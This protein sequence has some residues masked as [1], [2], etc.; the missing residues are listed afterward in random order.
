MFNV[1][2]RANV[3]FQLGKE[4]GAE[5]KN[6]QAFIARDGQ[7]GA[8][9]V[10]KRIEKS[11]LA[12]AADFYRESRALY[13]SAHPNVVQVHYAC[14]D[15]DNI[16]IAM[17]FYKNGSVRGLMATRHLSSRE[18]AT[19]GCQVLSGLHNIHSKGLVHFDIK[20]DNVLLSDRQEALISDFGLCKP[21]T[22]GFATPD[23]IYEPNWPPEALQ[24]QEFDA[25]YDIFQA[26]LTL[27][28]MCVGLVTFKEQ[29]EAYFSDDGFDEKAFSKD[30]LAGTYPKRDLLPPHVPARLKRVIKTCLEVSPDDRYQTALDAMNALAAVEGPELDWFY[31]VS[32]GERVWKKDCQGVKYVF[33]VSS[34]GGATLTKAASGGVAR[35]VSAGSFSTT[36]PRD[37]AKVLGTYD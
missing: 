10:I 6:S 8:D 4:I 17:P 37:I 18:V 33:T 30:I 21:L 5:G 1:V 16:F 9:I 2:T 20:A 29:Y 25:R 27:Y 35:R 23:G 11:S 14:E 34:Q 12:D 24:K 7:L 13:A 3:A 19:I 22:N 28:A 32:N 15:G 26:G 31:S 36:R